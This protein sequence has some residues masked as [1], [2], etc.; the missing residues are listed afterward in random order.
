MSS[1]LRSTALTIALLFIAIPAS[2]DDATREQAKEAYDRGVDAHKHGEMA[3]AAK[4]F[5]AADA[6]QPSPQALQAALDAA[7]D[8]DDVALGAEL[9]ERAKRE[10]ATPGL[11]SSITAASMK[12]NSRAGRIKIVCPAS[13]TCNA[14]VDDAPVG[15]GRVIWVPIGQRTVSVQV[16]GRSSVNKVVD[17]GAETPL[18]VVAGKELTTRPGSFAADPGTDPSQTPRRSAMQREGL[19]PV[20][21]YAGA[22]IT[23]ALAAFTTYLMVHTSSVHGDFDDKGCGKLKTKECMDL[24]DSGKSSQSAAN[25]ALV[26][27]G[28]AALATVAIGV[29][30]VNWHRDGKSASRNPFILTF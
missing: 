23:V 14:K 10:P 8:A 25:V 4:E 19:S 30:F 11:A 2:A 22:G 7:I 9:L 5:A 6:L 12:F 18:E 28:L 24:A 16:D 29:G 1:A 17:V 20:V 21:F 15:V 13:A 3:R 27:T 26:F